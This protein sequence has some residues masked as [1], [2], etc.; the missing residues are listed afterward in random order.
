M[1]T[2]VSQPASKSP[3]ASLW[4]RE[5]PFTLVLILTILGVAYTSFSKQ[6]M[7]VY[8]EILAPV[9]G[10]LCV[11]YGWNSESDQAGRL[12]LLGTQLLHWIAFLVVMNLLLLPN[13]QKIFTA[14]ATGLAIFTLL[15]LGTFTAGVHVL[16]LADLSSESDYGARHPYDRVD[17]ELNSALCINCSRRAGSCRRVLVAS[18]QKPEYSN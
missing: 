18:A 1:S 10:L 13:V 16:F 3:K 11:A 5:L 8:W 14:N 2:A 15:T 7:I 6:P 17:R 4:L 12:R 9:I